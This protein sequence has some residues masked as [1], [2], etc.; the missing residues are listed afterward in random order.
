MQHPAVGAALAAR[1]AVAA[2]MAMA[3]RS[4]HHPS[5]SCWN[6]ASDMVTSADAGARQLAVAMHQ[7]E[8]SPAGARQPV[9]RPRQRRRRETLEM[10]FWFVVGGLGGLAALAAVR[11]VESF[12]L[13]P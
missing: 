5:H 2:E 4:G 8:T 1:N 11:V 12:F 6:A 10:C 3:A 7:T 9:P 13:N